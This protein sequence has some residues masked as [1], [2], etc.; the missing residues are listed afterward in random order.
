[1]KK[2]MLCIDILFVLFIVSCGQE[3]DYIDKNL[4]TKE[5]VFTNEEIDFIENNDIDIDELNNYL[6][7]KS[8][9]LFKYFDYEEIRIN[10]NYS[11]LQA[12][13]YINNPNYYSFYLLPKLA[14]SNTNYPI[15]V[16]KCYYLDRS[17]I[18][19]DLVEIKNYNISYIKR[20]SEE[21]YC[22]K[23]LI[24]SL[25]QMYNDALIKNIELTVFS[26]YR[27]YE[28]QIYLYYNVNNMNDAT[29]ARPGF[30]EH[31][32]GLALDISTLEYGL[33]NY[34]K[35]SLTYFWLINNCYKYGFILRYPDGSESFTGYSEESWHFRYVGKEI[36][37]DIYNK[38][39]TLEEYIFLNFEIFNTPTL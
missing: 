27:S 21:M 13:N 38:E 10:N 29:S 28:K 17:Y 31:Q 4:K 14:N 7:Y 19:S 20:E 12:L 30:S 33:T 23:E 6:E 39:I 24:N 8:F 35:E 36:A 11:Y 32:T 26:A 5:I 34:F 37:T 16:N 9:N 2:I 3:I 15:L 1:M 22:S 18:P 25:V